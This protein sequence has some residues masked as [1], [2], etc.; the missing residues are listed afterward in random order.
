MKKLWIALLLLVGTNSAVAGH[1]FYAPEKC[2]AANIYHEARGE[3]LEGMFAVGLVTINRKNDHRWKDSI[4]G[5][6]YQKHQFSWTGMR[7]LPISNKFSWMLSNGIAI[8]LLKYQWAFQ[9]FKA[10]YYV[11]KDLH[12]KIE[13]TRKVNYYGNIGN[14][15]FYY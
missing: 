15:S 8:V 2:L 14:H 12:H 11:R 7:N 9:S 4:C 5:V 10:T 13:W 1:R 3:R 6:V